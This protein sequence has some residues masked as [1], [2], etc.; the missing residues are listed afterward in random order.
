MS[1]FKKMIPILFAVLSG[2]MLFLSFSPAGIDFLGWVALVPLILACSKS[3]ARR[4]ILLGWLAGAVF[5][6]GSLY[7]L[8]NVTWAGY[9]ALSCYCALYFIPF[10]VL[11]ALRP[12][13]WGNMARLKNLGWMVAVSAV[14]A[15]SEYLRATV[16]TGFPW[17]ALGI[18]QY[19][20][21]SLIQIAELGGVYILS[22]LMVFVNAGTAIT[23]LQYAS[24]HRN[25]GYKLHIEL[26]TAM[27]VLALA[28][29]F[30]FRVLLAPV[31]DV[32]PVRAALIQPNIPEVG[33]WELADPEV[34][35]QRLT[36]LTDLATHTADL[37][38]II[39]PET[40]LPDCVR[41]SQRSADLVKRFS[42]KVPM[43]V[44]S[45]DVE[46]TEHGT[47]R[48]YNGSML[49]NTEGNLLDMY[50]KQHLV[51]F[52]E[53]IPF[54]G[55][56]AW[57]DALTPVDSS[58][59]SGQETTLF[60]PPEDPRGFSVL[61]CFEDTVPYL[62]RRAALRGATWLVNQTNDSWF[63][64]D[65][66]S[67]QHVAH[68]VFRAVENRLPLVRCANTGVTCSIDAKGKI[69]QTLEPRMDGFHVASV[70]PADPDRPLTFYTRHGD[71]FAQAC[72]LASV[73]LFISLAF[74]S[75]KKESC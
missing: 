33:N 49:F 53:Y 19:A 38:L 43:L 68:A 3:T 69:H 47:Q 73:A 17:N 50:Y 60:Y 66:G 18:S 51:L 14:W 72:L 63:D 12:G 75:R 5:F 64:P 57:I 10:A 54:D 27:F 56:I 9:L 13:G 21:S 65:C 31:P 15:A 4:A 59:A 30:G 71:R 22:A 16:F 2:V 58:F 70:D 25:F 24:G 28:S 29:S 62:A 37:D 6:V 44:G 35:Y 45:M 26:M 20:Q 74:N 40:A 8:R 34:I 61:I 23:I 46:W 7:W 41:Y 11:V 36:D 67:V 55:R 1:I 48:Y 32:D 39:W 42:A 52:G